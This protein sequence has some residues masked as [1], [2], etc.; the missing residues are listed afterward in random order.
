MAKAEVQQQAAGEAKRKAI[1]SAVSAIEKQFGKGSILSMGDDS[2]D[3]EIP[4]L[5][6]RAR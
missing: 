4:E 3:K 1:E 6:D 2:V 5:L